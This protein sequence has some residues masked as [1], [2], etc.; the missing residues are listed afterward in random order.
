MTWHLKRGRRPRGL[1]CN[2]LTISH[3]PKGRRASSVSR[4]LS[5]TSY[6]K[7]LQYHYHG[8]GIQPAQRQHFPPHNPIHLVPGPLPSNVGQLEILTSRR[9][10]HGHSQPTRLLRRRSQRE[11]PLT[12]TQRPHSPRRRG[13]A[14][15]SRQ[16]RAL[17]SRSDGQE[18]RQAESTSP[19]WFEL[20][21]LLLSN[22]LYICLQPQRDKSTGVF[23]GGDVL[24]RT[25][26]DLYAFPYGW[27]SVGAVLIRREGVGAVFELCR[28][29]EKL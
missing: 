18:R 12:S 4:S 10:R 23:E 22:R 14:E 1:L 8:H 17:C 21:L 13:Y 2:T 9:A 24:Y 25:W 29:L 26:I 19:E 28:V 5:I 15:S 3:K 16:H 7:S 11:C 6:P 27:N 20:G